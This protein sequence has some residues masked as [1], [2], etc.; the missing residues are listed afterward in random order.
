MTSHDDIRAICAGLPGA[1]EG[2]E[3][4]GFA[5]QV[6]GKWKGFCW[7][8]MERV[9]E[10]RPKVENVRVLAVRVPNLQAKEALIASDPAAYFD[11]PH[12]RG[13]PAVLV[14]LD[15]IAPAEI[16]DTLIEGYRSLL[17]PAKAPK[18][19]P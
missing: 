4:F 10:K 14:R 11:E 2:E 7:T 17:P 18:A 8:W 6:K 12:Y 1:S 15:A 5:V 9:Q 3:R 19:V 16:E 13:F